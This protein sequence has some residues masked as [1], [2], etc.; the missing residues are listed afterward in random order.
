MTPSNGD[1]LLFDA[2]VW[3]EDAKRDHFDFITGWRGR[4]QLVDHV[5]LHGRDSPAARGVD[6]DE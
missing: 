6:V 3:V 2:A 4:E 1:D 5:R